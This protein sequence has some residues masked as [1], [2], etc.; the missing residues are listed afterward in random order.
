MKLL[1]TDKG[2]PK[3]N[4]PLAYAAAVVSYWEFFLGQPVLVYYFVYFTK[5]KVLTKD[6]CISSMK[7]C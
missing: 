3:N 6:Y 1:E 5:D 7:T 2:C 4:S